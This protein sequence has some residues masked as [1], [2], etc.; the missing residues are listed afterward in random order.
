MSKFDP[1]LPPEYLCCLFCDYPLENKGFSNFDD[2]VCTNPEC[3]HSACFE[4]PM[5]CLECGS[6]MFESNHD[7]DVYYYSCITCSHNEIRP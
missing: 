5:W 4:P 2:W 6:A 7:G 3:E 1:P